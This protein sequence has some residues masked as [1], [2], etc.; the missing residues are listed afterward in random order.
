[1][2]ISNVLNSYMII[3]DLQRAKPDSLTVTGATKWNGFKKET[4]VN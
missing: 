2:S 3:Y 4:V 1:M